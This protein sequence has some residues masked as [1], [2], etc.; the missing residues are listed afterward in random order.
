[1][2]MAMTAAM[3]VAV[4]AKRITPDNPDWYRL[5]GLKRPCRRYF[6]AK[7]EALYRQPEGITRNKRYSRG[8]ISGKYRWEKGG[9]LTWRYFCVKRYYRRG[10]VI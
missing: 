10:K 2:A 7:W 3:A 6:C 8:S 1:M 9:G 4:T 5:Q